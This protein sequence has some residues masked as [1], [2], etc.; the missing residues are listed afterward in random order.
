MGP[1]LSSELEQFLMALEDRPHWHG[2]Q[3]GFAPA[4]GD[5]AVSLIEQAWWKFEVAR[6][7]QMRED[8]GE[9]EAR[10]L[11]AEAAAEE[12]RDRAERWQGSEDT[13]EL[14][15][16]C[17]QAEAAAEEARERAERWQGWADEQ[18]LREL[19][20]ETEHMVRL[21]EVRQQIQCNFEEARR[22][23]VDE[24][25]AL[26]ERIVEL[27]E[28]RPP[29]SSSSSQNRLGEQLQRSPSELEAE[30]EQL[31][32]ALARTGQ[33]EEQCRELEDSFRELA[34]REANVARAEADTFITADEFADDVASDRA[35]LEA[36]WEVLRAEQDR[37]RE[38]WYRQGYGAESFCSEDAGAVHRTPQK[39]QLI[40]SRSP[41][42]KMSPP[43]G[44]AKVCSG[45]WNNSTACP[46]SFDKFGKRWDTT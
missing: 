29:L 21:R 30:L 41:S 3:E 43:K 12:A 36:E 28:E 14:E 25:Q 2:P 40:L 35:Q 27:E 10:C 8:T 22:G 24:N 31:R 16:R 39:P 34:A 1:P 15:A 42:Q 32:A 46:H 9:L 5:V 38:I 33:K 13:G 11:R 19:T 7:R 44:E 23:L 45:R 17:L 37:L 20:L 4:E 26:K 18:Q 6:Q